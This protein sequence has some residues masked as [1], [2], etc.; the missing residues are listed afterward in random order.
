MIALLLLN[1][2]IK[3]VPLRHGPVQTSEPQ[4]H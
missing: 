3:D 4:A 2:V 1:L